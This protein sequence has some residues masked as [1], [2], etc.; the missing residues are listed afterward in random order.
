MSIWITGDIHGNPFERFATACFP[1]QKDKELF[2]D[3]KSSVVIICGDFG[4]VWD[5]RGES[6]EEKYNLKWLE[7]KP[8]T[9]IFVDGNH[10]NHK[11]LAEYPV[12]E[13]NGGKVH[14]I[15]PHVLHLMR[16]EVYTI[17]GIKFFAFGGASS[18]D[19]KDGILDRN[20]F[21]DE[22]DFKET[23]KLWWRQG[24]MFRVKDMSWWSEELPTDAEMENGIK[25]L[26]AHDNKVDYIISHTPSSSIIALLGHGF[27]KQDVLT[28]Y[29]EDIR[30]TTE[31]KKH[32]SGHMHVDRYVNENDVILFEDIERID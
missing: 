5:F 13:W 30:A 29:L 8:W 3:D 15:R 20:D 25:N 23:Y 31:Y 26:A 27:Y 7:E 11:R 9:T 22:E 21:A 10:E 14:E 4:C 16:G 6:N 28:K 19:I 1:E 17:N 12:K 2:P 24:R 32:Y 18:H